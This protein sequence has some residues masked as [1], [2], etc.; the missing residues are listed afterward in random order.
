M[1]S[2]EHIVVWDGQT[3]KTLKQLIAAGGGSSGTSDY[4]Q[5][6]NRPSIN[7][8]TLTGNKTGAN[9]GLEDSA[10][11]VTS[12]SSSSTN[13][14]YPSALCVYTLVGDIE[15]ALAALI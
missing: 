12:I 6:N 2:D 9:L 4:D 13:D 3:T 7:G 14:Q 11:K 10:N 8:N 5:L 1:P 15:T